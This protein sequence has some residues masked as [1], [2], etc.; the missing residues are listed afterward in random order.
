[1]R[2]T[3]ISKLV[4]YYILITVLLCVVMVEF[5]LK[6]CS[7]L[8]EDPRVWWGSSG[9]RWQER[10]IRFGNAGK[11]AEHWFGWWFKVRLEATDLEICNLLHLTGGV[12]EPFP[13]PHC[14]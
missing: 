3:L 7:I 10:V 9:N 1:M 13:L 8:M 2:I 6:A 4:Y 5:V 12:V 11:D 14:V